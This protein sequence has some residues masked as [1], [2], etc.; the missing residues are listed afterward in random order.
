MKP[1]ILTFLTFANQ[2]T[3]RKNNR[4]SL[5]PLPDVSMERAWRMISMWSSVGAI[6]GWPL[7][8]E[9]QRFTWVCLRW[10]FM[11]KTI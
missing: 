11:F 8:M 10:L 2:I 3:P 7:S 4:C 9:S 5:G 1:S 6:C